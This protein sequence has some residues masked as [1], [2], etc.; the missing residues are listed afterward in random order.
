MRAWAID[1]AV[2]LCLACAGFCALEI[3]GA[4]RD[5][6]AEI[7][8]GAARLNTTI[9]LLDASL[10]DL[11][12]METNT[13]RTEAEMAGLLNASRHDM[14]TAAEKAVLLDRTKRILDDADASVRQLGAAAEQLG[15]VS[16]AVT[17]AVTGV[18]L[19]SHEL[20]GAA[21][22]DLQDPALRGAAANVQAATAQLNATSENISAATQDIAAFVHRETTPVRGTWN[23]IKAFL[24]EFAGPAAQV[25]TAIR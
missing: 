6:R 14:L 11:H 1:L 12:A 3:G 25:T 18:A 5:L 20:L 10:A 4:V 15:G 9:N 2:L 8:R 23:V 19:D 24:R 16:P 21:T 22:A 13:T 17:E 7:P